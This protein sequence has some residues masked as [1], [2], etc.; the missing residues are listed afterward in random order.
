VRLVVFGASGGVGR[1]VVERAVAAGQ[2]V[3]A[4]AR[5]GSP[6]PPGAER[7]VLDVLRDDLRPA[8][9]GASVVISCLGMRR[10]VVLNPWSALTCPE[11]FTS[12]TAARVVEAAAAEGVGRALAVSAAGVGDSGPAMNPLMRALVASSS[13]GVAYRDLARME[14]VYLRSGLEVACLRPVTLVNGPPTDRVRVVERF[15]V[16]SVIRRSDVA[17]ALL[18]RQRG[19]LGARTPQI[20]NG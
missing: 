19:P 14:E 18:T 10:Q 17:G 6:T 13:I 12:L 8:L 15:A 3:R 11:D 9:A 2:D 4:V 7:W 1:W 16:W 5:E 20:A